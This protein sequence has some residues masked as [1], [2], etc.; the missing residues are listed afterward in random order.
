MMRVTNWARWQRTK[1]I[2]AL[3]LLTISF[4]CA[5]GLGSPD[6]YAPIPSIEGFIVSMSLL[7]TLT[8]N[9]I[10]GDRYS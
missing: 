6:D 7:V 10:K 2:V 3:I 9:I 8:L 5:G 1:I 4:V